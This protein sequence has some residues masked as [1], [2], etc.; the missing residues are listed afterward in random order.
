MRKTLFTA[1]VHQVHGVTRVSDLLIIWGVVL[2]IGLVGFLKWGQK[3][4]D[5]QED[6]NFQIPAQFYLIVPAAVALIALSLTLQFAWNA[7]R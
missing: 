3:K 1:Q 4:G 5:G 6:A 2:F 7:M